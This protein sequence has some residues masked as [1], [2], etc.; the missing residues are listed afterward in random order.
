MIVEYAKEHIRGK[1]VNLKPLMKH[2]EG[3]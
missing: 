3:P 1:Q 2:I